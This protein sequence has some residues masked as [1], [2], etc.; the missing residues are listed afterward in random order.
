MSYL[1]VVIDNKSDSTDSFFTYH[2][3]D[4][5]VKTGSKVFLPFAR[6]KKLREGYVVS[7]FEDEEMIDEK[8]RGKLKSV[9]HVDPDV[10]LTEEMVRTAF[11]MKGRYLCRYIDAI[12]CF[13]PAGNKAK[14]REIQDSLAGDTGSA[15]FIETLTDEQEEALA[16]ISKPIQNHEHDRFLIHGVTGS[17]KTEVYIRAAELA[18]QQGRGVI[19][20]VPEISLTGQITE[21]F[22]GKFGRDTVAILHSR[23]SAG[24]RYDQWMKIRRGDVRIVIGA[25]SAVFA[26]VEDLG[27]IVIDE[28]HEST[29]KSDFTPKYDTAEVAI[30]RL[31]DKDSQG[32]LILGSATPSVVSYSRSQEGIY[33][34]IRLT[35]RY[36]D[37]D[38]PRA[39]IVDMRQELKEGNRSILSRRLCEEMSAELKAGRQVMLFLN[40]RG[41]STFVSCRECGFVAKCPTCGLSLTYHK[42]DGTLTC[43]Y[44]GHSELAPKRCPE[45][46]SKYVRYFGSGTEKVEDFVREMFPEYTA[47]RVD[48]DSIKKKGEL[49]KR[50]KDFEKGRT[51]ILIGTQLIAKG[52]DFRN[53]GLVGIVSADVS[54]N[55]P[56][57]RS[58]ERAFQ[59][60]TQA[61]GRAG[62][63]EREGKVIIQT[64][65]PEH[66]AIE[67]AAS[68]DYEG[69]YQ[70]E[71]KFRK[72]MTYPPYSDII[73]I[74]FT[75][76]TDGDAKAGAEAWHESILAKMPP[77]ER[78][79]VF[80]P[81]QAYMSKIRD[82]Y[83]YSLIIK[84]PKGKRHAYARLLWAVKQEH[85][86]KKGRKKYVAVIDINPYSF[87]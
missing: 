14:R 62:R 10:S 56:D 63:G 72:Y 83:R 50:L 51:R 57:F 30:K 44:C 45:C 53:V 9:D 49:K 55:I 87:S 54:L 73:Q 3:D 69:F 38:M 85:S 36:N 24:E 42:N 32:V 76:E 74:L 16:R 12:K 84:C 29:Y 35:K 81:Q 48:L 64:Y 82:T 34:L 21:R 5:S 77:E 65:D 70:S 80:P 41:Y 78:V 58:P 11:W 6:S 27:L 47:A 20:L 71:I 31:Q 40:R 79:N 28:E 22:L 60:I 26:P 75:A 19:I 67:L 39:E 52:L 2:C 46:G 1:N 17:G 15:S 37:V 7:A 68:H 86:N 43:H 33:K 13:T 23:L 25:R 61:S 18:L 8:L 66:Y 59:L 4:D